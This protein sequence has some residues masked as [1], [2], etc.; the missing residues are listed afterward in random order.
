MTP[1]LPSATVPSVL[2]QTG[3][4]PR[5][6]VLAAAFAA[7]AFA[8]ATVAPAPAAAQTSCEWTPVWP[9]ALA[10]PV[11]PDRDAFHLE[12]I[13]DCAPWETRLVYPD[14]STE[15]LLSQV[16]RKAED[17]SL[18]MVFRRDSLLSL[19]PDTVYTIEWEWITYDAWKEGPFGDEVTT[20]AAPYRFV[21]GPARD[22]AQELSL[23]DLTIDRFELLPD[24]NLAVFQGSWSDPSSLAALVFRVPWG[25]PRRPGQFAGSDV[26]SFF[27]FPTADGPELQFEFPMF[28]RGG[29]ER[30]AYFRAE[31]ETAQFRNSRSEEVC[32]RNGCATAPT[33]PSLGAFGLA[34]LAF[35]ARR[36]RARAPETEAR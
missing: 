8:L 4:S 16:F 25:S 27:V 26:R 18:H 19:E 32:T 11:P 6:R 23:D 17:T 33:V 14:G 7:L 30:C 12:A 2:E 15:P 10:A 22:P 5:A 3:S 20:P 9:E 29:G 28:L 13:A 34:V 35:A 24:Q 31:F 21:T 36:R 1:D